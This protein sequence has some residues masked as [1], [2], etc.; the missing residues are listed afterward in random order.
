MSREIPR[1]FAVSS[2]VLPSAPQRNTS[3]SLR[4]RGAVREGILFSSSNLSWMLLASIFRIFFS[5]FDSLWFIF[6]C[7]LASINRS[8]APSGLGRE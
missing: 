7:L 4:E 1:I 2:D 3:C 5:V 8:V 6:K